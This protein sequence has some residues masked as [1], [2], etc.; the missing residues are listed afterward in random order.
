MTTF[1]YHTQEALEAGLA[2]WQAILHLQDWEITVALVPQTAWDDRGQMGDCSVQSQSFS[3][4]IRIATFDTLDHIG[5]RGQE[6]MERTLVH[7][8]LHCLFRGE[9]LFDGKP[10]RSQ[11]CAYEHAIEQTARVLVELDRRVGADQAAKHFGTATHL[12]GATR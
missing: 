10:S 6:D 8:L 9:Q 11:R 4:S 7:E 1:R 5:Y 2:K 3:A 12:V